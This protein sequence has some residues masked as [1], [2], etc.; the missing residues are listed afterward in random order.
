MGKRGRKMG[1][2]NDYLKH[3]VLLIL[4]K[5]FYKGEIIKEVIEDFKEIC[6]SEVEE[7]EDSFRVL[8]KPIQEK[9]LENLGCEFS[10]YVLGL[11]KNRLVI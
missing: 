7:C 3:E 10:N 11:M 9:D 4:K 2:L 1:I 5:D 8:L 6:L